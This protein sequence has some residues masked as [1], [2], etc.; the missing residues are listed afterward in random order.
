VVG[1][2]GLLSTGMMEIDLPRVIRWGV[3]SALL[4]FGSVF[5]EK[6][7]EINFSHWVIKLGDSSY[8]LY[9]SH[10][11]T[12]NAMGK[13]WRTFI[14]GWYE[15][16]IMVTI[17]AALIVGYLSYLII[18]RPVTNYLHRLYEVQKGMINKKVYEQ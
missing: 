5:L 3:P 6:Q 10:L 18:E 4:V 2:I 8:S 11:F 17:P 13:I 15:I 12:I 9:L 14:G 16:F 1:A 7:R